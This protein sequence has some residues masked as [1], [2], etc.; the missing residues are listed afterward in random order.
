MQS[1]DPLNTLSSALQNALI[2]DLPDLCYMKGSE[3]CYRRPR[4]DEVD[5]VMFNQSWSSTAL[6]FSD[7]IGGQ[8]FCSAYTAIVTSERTACVYF[9]ER[10]AYTVDVRNPRY[11]DDL[12]TLNLKDQRLAQKFYQAKLP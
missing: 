3:E 1:S 2:T 7:G 6:G 8:A 9:G 4:R 10:L 5:I 11:R 12:A